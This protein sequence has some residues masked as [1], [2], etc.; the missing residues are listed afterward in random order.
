VISSFLQIPPLRMSHLHLTSWIL[1]SRTWSKWHLH[2]ISRRLKNQSRCPSFRHLWYAN[3]TH[4]LRWLLLA[5]VMWWLLSLQ[6]SRLL[7]WLKMSVLSTY[8]STKS[9]PSVRGW[10]AS[11]TT[12]R[13]DYYIGE[14]TCQ[15]YQQYLRQIYSVC[16]S[17]KTQRQRTK[18]HIGKPVRGL[19]QNL[20]WQVEHKLKTC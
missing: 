20:F 6:D 5:L 4:S 12:S 15:D 13:K 2:V 1:K 9:S 8:G 11:S 10:P 19:R 17:A 14:W 18:Q 7:S 16:R 3:I